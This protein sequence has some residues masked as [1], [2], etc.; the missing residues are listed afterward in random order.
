MLLHQKDQNYFH[1][2]SVCFHKDFAITAPNI[3]DVYNSK[4]NESQLIENL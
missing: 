1:T 2:A 3:E 4:I